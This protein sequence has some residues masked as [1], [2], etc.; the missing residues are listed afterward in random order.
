MLSRVCML[1]AL[2]T[3][4]AAGIPAPPRIPAML[5]TAWLQHVLSAPPGLSVSAS[6]LSGY[7]YADNTTGR[8]RTD[9]AAFT[10][11][12]PMLSST[13]YDFLAR[14]ITVV[15]FTSAPDGNLSASCRVFPLSPAVPRPTFFPDV[16]LAYT[17]SS[18]CGEG[19]LQL[20]DL[21][22]FRQG[23]CTG[24]LA[25]EQ[26]SGIPVAE[27]YDCPQAQTVQVTFAG[28][29]PSLPKDPAFMRPP[30]ALCSAAAWE[31]GDETPLLFVRTSIF[32]SAGAHQL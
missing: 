23:N 13:Y 9:T 1:A 14:T 12:Q 29:L 18:A 20:C 17:G 16:P 30:P 5:S 2:A 32:I 22:A 11:G 7:Y 15:A 28:L 8:F 26:G 31:D 6:S 19:R 21:F 3:V 4:G 10:H 25:F 24:T 27:A